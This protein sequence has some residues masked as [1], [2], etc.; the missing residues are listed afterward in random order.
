MAPRRNTAMRAQQRRARYRARLVEG[1]REFRG[2]E[3]EWILPCT[4]S[5]RPIAF[6]QADTR[7]DVA[8][9]CIQYV[10]RR[11][12]RLSQRGRLLFQY[13][14]DAH[15][16]EIDKVRYEI[17][18]IQHIDRKRLKLRPR[19]IPYVVGDDRLRAASE[20]SCYDVHIV[21]I[22]KCDDVAKIIV[23]S[24]DAVR[25]GARHQLTQPF[26]FF[27]WM[28]R[29]QSPERS[30]HLVQNFGG[31]MSAHQIRARY[32]QQKVAQNGRDENIGVVDDRRAEHS[33]SVETEL[34]GK[35][36]ELVQCL[37]AL[38]ISLLLVLQNVHRLY[39]SVAAHFTEGNFSLF[40]ELVEVGPRY[41][42]DICGLLTRQLGILSNYH[43][44]F[45]R[46]HVLEN[47]QKSV[48]GRLRHERRYRL[49]AAG[50][51]DPEKCISIPLEPAEGT[52]RLSRRLDFGGL[53]QIMRAFS[54]H[55]QSYGF[56]NVLTISR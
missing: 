52:Q 22:G 43:N 56:D 3:R 11:T 38:F 4:V 17:I 9:Q 10:V 19:K 13:L 25:G 44:V 2:Q 36:C 41:V 40:Q 35:P 39:A 55:L 34:L 5:A 6:D 14:P 49:L 20:S 30:C 21:R 24:D 42:E 27:G 47:L 23:V 31:E 28:L 45:A 1:K 26:E 54:H 16:R 33:P 37:S 15:G 29:V 50:D 48:E 12:R 32:T 51:F 18:R 53:R 8:T 46:R 7:R